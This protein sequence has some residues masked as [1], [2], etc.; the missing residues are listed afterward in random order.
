MQRNGTNTKM[1]F[2]LFLDVTPS[3]KELQFIIQKIAQDQLPANPNIESWPA[4]GVKV[5]NE[6]GQIIGEWKIEHE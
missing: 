4:K 6:N 3:Q 1:T 5:R 2:T